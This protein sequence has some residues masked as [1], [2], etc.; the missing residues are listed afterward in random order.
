MIYLR[1]CHDVS[2]YFSVAAEAGAL[3]PK[4]C[5]VF[6]PSLA[7]S[8]TAQ[9]IHVR[10][11]ERRRLRHARAATQKFNIPY[12]NEGCFLGSGRSQTD[13]VETKLR[14]AATPRP[15]RRLGPRI[16]AVDY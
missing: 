7:T 2:A 15:H 6:A 4:L 9:D 16:A 1:P 13:V 5:V 12:G 10:S 3:H 14:R 11:R 8:E